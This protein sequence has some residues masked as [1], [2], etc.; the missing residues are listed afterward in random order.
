MRVFRGYVLASELRLLGILRSSHTRRS[1]KYGCVKPRRRGSLLPEGRGRL[2]S[3]GR[4]KG[5]VVDGG[6]PERGRPDNG[7]AG[8]GPHHVQ[9]GPG[10]DLGLLRGH[11]GRGRGTQRR[12]GPK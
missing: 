5:L 6:G 1:R 7:A 2:P 11:G 10:G 9:A 12:G 4:R 8:R 3:L